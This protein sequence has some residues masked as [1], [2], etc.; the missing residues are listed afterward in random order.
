[1]Q[2]T[3][4]RHNEIVVDAE[5]WVAA[6]PFSIEAVFYTSNAPPE[7][8]ERARAVHQRFLAW[9]EAFGVNATHV[10]LLRLE[11]TA[12]TGDARGHTALGFVM[13]T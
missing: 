13:G 2:G 10:P 1:M 12:D 3:G 8:R 5:A 4:C 6:M 9:V 7:R 11:V